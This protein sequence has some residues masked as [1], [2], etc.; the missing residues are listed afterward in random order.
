MSYD[1]RALPQLRDKYVASVFAQIEDF[2]IDEASDHYITNIEL[3]WHM[4]IDEHIAVDMWLSQLDA[5]KD[6]RQLMLVSHACGNEKAYQDGWDE[7]F[8][9]QKK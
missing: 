5:C 8:A 4:K 1:W 6:L 7:Y 9:G 3:F 2:P